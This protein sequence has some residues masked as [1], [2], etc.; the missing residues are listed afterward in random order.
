MPS[1]SHVRDGYPALRVLSLTTC[2]AL[3]LLRTYPAVPLPAAPTVR[4]VPARFNRWSFGGA[5][6]AKIF[7]DQWNLG[8]RLRGHAVE[9][10]AQFH[11]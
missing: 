11:I 10:W 1:R 5:S 2:C 6:A 3:I 8:G 4:G 9:S 7:G